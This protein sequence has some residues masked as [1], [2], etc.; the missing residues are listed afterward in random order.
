MFCIYGIFSLPR[1]P[2]LAI[3]VSM[4]YFDLV[5]FFENTGALSFIKRGRQIQPRYYRS[6]KSDKPGER[7]KP[8]TLGDFGWKFF[9]TKS[10]NHP[11]LQ[12]Y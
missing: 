5:A 4:W 1:V 7:G 12:G 8:H 3:H 2:S 11:H 6:L 9:S 10:P